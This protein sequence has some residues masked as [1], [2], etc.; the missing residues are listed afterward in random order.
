M[1]N[2]LLATLLVLFSLPVPAQE[3][4]CKAVARKIKAELEAKGDKR[5]SLRIVD[6]DKAKHD[7]VVGTCNDG[8][9]KIVY[10][11]D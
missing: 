6:A 7:K 10:Q 3:N 2:I 4:S 5:F 1:K 9:K 11:R 8:G